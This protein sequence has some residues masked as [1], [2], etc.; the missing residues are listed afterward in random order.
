MKGQ[1]AGGPYTQCGHR[2]WGYSSPVHIS[3]IHAAV[4]LGKSDGQ[5]DAGQQEQGAPAQAEPERILHRVEEEPL[6]PDSN[7]DHLFCSQGSPVTTH[8]FSEPGLCS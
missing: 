8:S 1:V 5:D 6:G 4:E 3:N 2:G 7:W